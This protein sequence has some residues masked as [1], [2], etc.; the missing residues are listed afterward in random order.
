MKTSKSGAP[1]YQTNPLAF[2]AVSPRISIA[3][4]VFPK[5]TVISLV[6]IS[7]SHLTLQILD[8]HHA[9]SLF[10]SVFSTSRQITSLCLGFLPKETQ[11]E[12]CLPVPVLFGVFLFILM[13]YC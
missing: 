8:V 6:G 11:P 13:F 9:G 7:G 1:A 12:G 10:S 5:K 4:V 3:A 2:T